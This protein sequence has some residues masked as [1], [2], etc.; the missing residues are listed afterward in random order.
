VSGLA[1]LVD[2]MPTLLELL[3]VDPPD[4]GAGY[5]ALQGV[6][7]V[8][9]METGRT[10]DEP[11]LAERVMFLP[12]GDYEATLRAPERAVIWHRA[13]LVLC[14][15]MMHELEM[16]PKRAPGPTA[17]GPTWSSTTTRA[18]SSPT[19]PSSGAWRPAPGGSRSSAWAA[20]TASPP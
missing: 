5:A 1:S 7:L 12:D 11:V 6:S 18:A 17:R 15:A 20:A 8:R 2:V 14:D 10:R 3:E 16:I 13:R 19:T 9:A 4:T